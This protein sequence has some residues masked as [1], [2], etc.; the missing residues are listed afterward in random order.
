MKNYILA[1]IALAIPLSLVQ[2]QARSRTLEGG[3]FG[4]LSG[5]AIGGMAGGGRGAGIGAGVG[6]GVGLL[7]GAAADAR[8]QDREYDEYSTSCE[9]EEC[10]YPEYR[11]NVINGQTRHIFSETGADGKTYQYYFD[12][13]GTKV[14]LN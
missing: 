11:K 13:M 9:G 14:Y 4:G 8:A 10:D 7:A 1:I 2:L 6:L 12:N 5:A 3:L